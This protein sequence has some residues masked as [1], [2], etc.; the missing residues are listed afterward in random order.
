MNLERPIVESYKSITLDCALQRQK[1]ELLYLIGRADVLQ[2]ELVRCTLE[3]LRDLWI[4]QAYGYKYNEV[5][6]RLKD[7]CQRLIDKLPPQE[8]KMRKRLTNITRWCTMEELPSYLHMIRTYENEE[9]AST[10]GRLP[11]A[12]S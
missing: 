6:V 8:R 12:G 2:M 11:R 5:L 3:V 7:E 10:A 9:A 4:S 1:G